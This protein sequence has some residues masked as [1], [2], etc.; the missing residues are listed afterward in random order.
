[1]KKKDKN[2][3][4]Y[5]LGEFSGKAAVLCTEA[6]I[7]FSVIGV[8]CDLIWDISERRQQAKVLTTKKH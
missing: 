8:A 5:L 7:V 3:K 4:W 1:M 6:L 2:L